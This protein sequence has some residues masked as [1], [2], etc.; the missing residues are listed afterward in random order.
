[1][2]F[3]SSRTGAEITGDEN[4][5]FSGN[6]K[7]MPDGTIASATIRKFIV[8][9]TQE[10]D[11]QFQIFWKLIDG[12]FKGG[13]VKQTLKPYA[14]DDIA[15][16]RFLNMFMRIYKICGVKPTH[17]NEPTN[18][19]LS[20]FQGHILCIKIGNG[21]I[22]G[23]ERTWVREVHAENA[24]P[25]ETG[26]VVAHVGQ[27]KQNNS[28]TKATASVDSRKTSLPNDGSGIPF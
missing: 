14:T 13:E 10:N 19:D 22:E 7:N 12:D 4:N 9:T 27:P 18:D 25:T 6:F 2:K 23:A 16:Q 1:M 8:N 11:V 3:W 20:E 5:S 17:E 26:N 21:V 15:A 28:E 24:Y